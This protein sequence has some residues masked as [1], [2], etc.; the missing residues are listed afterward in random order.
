MSASDG[1]VLVCFLVI[2]TDGTDVSVFG[3]YGAAIVSF[4]ALF[5]VGFIL[6]RKLGY[7]KGRLDEAEKWSRDNRVIRL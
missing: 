2:A 4:G 6:G 1:Y 7:A 3:A 5:M